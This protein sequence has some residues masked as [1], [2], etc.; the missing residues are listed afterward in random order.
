MKLLFSL[1]KR[2]RPSFKY[3]VAGKEI[4]YFF[5][6]CYRYLI[7]IYGLEGSTVYLAGVVGNYS[8]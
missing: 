4:H 1:I 2:F 7:K 3:Q 8:V 6:R 5:G